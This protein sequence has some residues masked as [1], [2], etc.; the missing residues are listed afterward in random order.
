MPLSLTNTTDYVDAT[1]NFT[2]ANAYFVKPVLGGVEQAA[3]AAF[4]LPANSPARQYLSIPM[5]PIPDGGPYQCFQ[6]QVGDADGDGEFELVCLRRYIGT[7]APTFRSLKLDCYRL[8]GT[9]LWRVD[10]GTNYT[11]GANDAAYFT[12][13]DLD[14]DGRSEVALHTSKGVVFGDGATIANVPGDYNITDCDGHVISGREF[15]SVL[16]GATGKELARTD[17]QPAVTSDPYGVWGANERPWYLWMAAG[18]LDGVHASIVT[19]RGIGGDTHQVYAWDFRRG[20]SGTNGTLTQRWSWSPAPGGGMGVSHNMLIYDVN[21]DGRDDIVNI[22]GVINSDGTLLYNNGLVHGDHFRVTD[23]DPDRPGAEFFAIQQNNPSLVGMGLYD[24]ATGKP[25]KAF[26]MA[27]LGDL[28]RGDAG[29]YDGGFRGVEFF[30]TMSG[31]YDCKGTRIN[32]NHQFPSWGIWWDA[33][34]QREI[35]TGAGADGTSSVINK[36]YPASGSDGRLYSIYTEGVHQDYGGWPLA[37]GDYLGDWREETI[38]EANTYDEI[39]IYSTT[40]PATN[41]LYTLMQNPAYRVANLCKGRIGA[42]FTDYYL[43]GGMAPPPPPA[44]SDARLVWRGGAGGNTWDTGLTANWATN[45][46]WLTNSWSTNVPAT[47]F[48]A[49]QT[50]LF[51]AHRLEQRAGPFERHAC[52]LATSR[53]TPQAI[54]LSPAPARSPAA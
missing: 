24:A 14:G 26:Y 4:T 53:F 49:G 46:F 30:S 34:L 54:T 41:R 8:D 10:S 45:W 47:T 19:Q 13:I 25:I 16:D 36:W 20:A 52:P 48:T 9:F 37:W 5:Q 40:I 17:Y 12:V 35:M 38:Q 18:Y 23:M 15:L 11:A 6:V 33:D 2:A 22:G 27:Q 44:F 32:A 51:D 42:S 7:T 1:A 39:R 43:G 21:N 31:M 28:S 3:S 29:D 50:L